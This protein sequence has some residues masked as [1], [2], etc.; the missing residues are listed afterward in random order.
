MVTD[1]VNNKGPS[2]VTTDANKKRR[3]LGL[4]IQGRKSRQKSYKRRRR[5]L[6]WRPYGISPCRVIS[7]GQCPYFAKHCK[8]YKDWDLSK[9]LAVPPCA[10]EISM[11]EELVENFSDAGLPLPL[12][13]T[14]AANI[15]RGSRSSDPRFSL[16]SEK[17]LTNLSIELFRIPSRNGNNGDNG[18]NI[19]LSAILAMSASQED[20]T[21]QLCGDSKLEVNKARNS[22]G[23]REDDDND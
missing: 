4:P 1:S 9:N 11:F 7:G 5:W 10:S 16:Q 18:D 21:P 14:I 2:V 6:F 12:S 8:K 3:R 22:A 15:L 13:Q 19:N 17:M 20:T 23:R